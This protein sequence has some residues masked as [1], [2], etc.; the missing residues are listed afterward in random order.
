MYWNWSLKV[1]DLSHL[2]ANLTQFGCQIWDLWWVVGRQLM[3]QLFHCAS[4][5]VILSWA[6]SLFIIV[7][8]VCRFFKLQVYL[9]D[10][11]L[12]LLDYMYIILRM[13][14]R[15]E[16][17]NAEWI[18]ILVIE[19]PVTRWMCCGFKFTLLSAPRQFRSPYVLVLR[20]IVYLLVANFHSYWTLSGNYESIMREFGLK[21]R[22]V[23]NK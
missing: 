16:V 14:F 2:G 8:D 6:Q 20:Y 11:F 22:G 21:I 13:I 9:Q 17:F 5:G 1:P 23:R 19:I 4:L 18:R 7:S 15:Q 12:F 10:Y 3:I